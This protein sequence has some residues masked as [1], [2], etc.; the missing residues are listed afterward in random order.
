MP[1]RRGA[2]PGTCTELALWYYVRAIGL[3]VFS[4]LRV[5]SIA[6]SCPRAPRRRIA[7]PRCVVSFYQIVSC[8]SVCLSRSLAP[9]RPAPRRAPPLICVLTFVARVHTRYAFVYTQSVC[10]TH[11]LR[12]TS[13][14]TP[15][16]RL[17]NN[18]LQLYGARHS[19]E[20]G[21]WKLLSEPGRHPSRVR[22]A[23]GVQR[24]EHDREE[25]EGTRLVGGAEVH[26]H[27]VDQGRHSEAHLVGV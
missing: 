21:P 15:A 11:K 10:E 25:G 20:R 3:Y 7:A 24:E 13:T 22:H 1:R 23:A 4:L 2:A 12:F 16:G 19:G 26:G 14:C 9:P 18:P 6:P 5:W 8:L 17:N 27:R